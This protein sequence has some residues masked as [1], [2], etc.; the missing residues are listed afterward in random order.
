M[1]VL[2]SDDP[3]Q[4]AIARETLSGDFMLLPTVLI[5]TEWV[6]RSSY[7]WP[8][9]RIAMAFAEIADL[10]SLRDAPARL[11]WAIARYRDGADF[12]DMIH[13]AEGSGAARFV[14][15]DRRLA[16]AAGPDAPCR[17]E[18]LG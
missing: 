18:T 2:V 1:R 13:V 17:I 10:P 9:E 8:R 11:G 7:G 6:L 15:F 16:P 3:H 14:T 5:E 12:A 4:A